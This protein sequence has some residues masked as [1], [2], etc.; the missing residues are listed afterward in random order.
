M[1]FAL[2]FFF[3]RENTQQM[4]RDIKNPFQLHMEQSFCRKVD[5]IQQYSNTGNFVASA[6]GR[7]GLNKRQNSVANGIDILGCD[8]MQARAD[9]DEKGLRSINSPGVARHFFFNTTV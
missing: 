6:A 9:S 3:F 2:F 8:K 4:L 7:Q 1:K 5:Y